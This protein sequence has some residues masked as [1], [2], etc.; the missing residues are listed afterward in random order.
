[1]TVAPKD[2]LQHLDLQA[3]F[4]L[5]GKS[6]DQALFA[7]KI[8]IAV[9][10]SVAVAVK[11]SHK[12]AL[13]GGGN[14]VVVARALTN[15][16]KNLIGRNYQEICHKVKELRDRDSFD[17]A[18]RQDL[19]SFDIVFSQVTV[20]D[21][22]LLSLLQRVLKHELSLVYGAS[23]TNADFIY[24]SQRWENILACDALLKEMLAPAAQRKQ[25]LAILSPSTVSVSAVVEKA[26]VVARQGSKLRAPTQAGPSF[27]ASQKSAIS[28]APVRDRS[29]AGN[30]APTLAD[31]VL[32]RVIPPDLPF[33]KAET[34]RLAVP[35]DRLP[36]VKMLARTQVSN[37]MPGELLTGEEE[38]TNLR[39]LVPTVNIQPQVNDSLSAD[40]GISAHIVD[41]L[42]GS[43]T[44]PMSASRMPLWLKLTPAIGALGMVLGVGISHLTKPKHRDPLVASLP[45]A[46]PVVSPTPTVVDDRAVMP[47]VPVTTG[48]A[49]QVSVHIPVVPFTAGIDASI[50]TAIRRSL[51]ANHV[52]TL[53][54]IPSGTADRVTN[55]RYFVDAVTHIAATQSP[56]ANSWHFVGNAAN[57]TTTLDSISPDCKS[58]AFTL[59]RGNAEV[60][61][62]TRV[63]FTSTPA[64]LIAARKRSGRLPNALP[65][66]VHLNSAQ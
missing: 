63:N 55:F 36:T 51:I 60:V 52:R 6:L 64:E 45:S 31:P 66:S 32:T 57:Y 7:L 33:A 56:L 2:S 21:F 16:L 44:L 10:Q 58:L 19:P 9:P 8:P 30:R 35:A 3:L 48:Y 13:D 59:Y 62:S 20:A 28:Q 34:H 15:V 1:M 65:A 12:K 5:R 53:E 43:T 11:L 40:S 29:S 49:P 17:V 24:L 14:D 54:C 4:D 23:L 38:K 47:N 46:A 27:K 50:A 41:E 61:P 26:P 25:I 42:S 18:V 37:V 39:I 22:N